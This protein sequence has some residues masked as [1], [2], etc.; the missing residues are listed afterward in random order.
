MADISESTVF[1][2]VGMFVL[3][4]AIDAI[5]GAFKFSAK[6]N[7]ENED[8]AKEKAETEFHQLRD[9]VDK[10]DRDMV[11]LTASHASHKD[12]MNSAL[13]SIDGRL[14]ALDNRVASQGKAY[15]ERIAEGFKRLE[16][17]LNRKLAQVVTPR[18]RR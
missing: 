15:E 7:V 13:G 1:I 9:K 14:I 6:R 17:E 10:L 18:G 12:L 2:A 8:K 11:S 16:I 3:P 5:I 4:R